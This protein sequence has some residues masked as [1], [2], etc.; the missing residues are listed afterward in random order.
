MHPV[1]HGLQIPNAAAAIRG[2]QEL[3]DRINTSVQELNHQFVRNP[4]SINTEI[5]KGLINQ[6]VETNRYLEE[7][8][9]GIYPNWWRDHGD[10]A[11]FAFLI[12]LGFGSLA[13]ITTN[14]FQFT[15]S[16]FNTDNITETNC[17]SRSISLLRRIGP[18]VARQALRTAAPDILASK[19]FQAVLALFI[20]GVAC[21]IIGGI[22]SFYADRKNKKENEIN[23]NLANLMQ[24]RQVGEENLAN[25]LKI[26][27]K[28][29]TLPQEERD[30]GM[31]TA[32]VKQIKKMP[33]DG[34]VKIKK[35]NL[36]PHMIEDLPH[37]NPLFIDYALLKRSLPSAHDRVRNTD[38]ADETPPTDS[39][40]SSIDGE[41][42]SAIKSMPILQKTKFIDPLKRYKQLWTTV[43]GHLGFHIKRLRV[44]ENL[45][46]KNGTA[47]AAEAELVV[48]EMQERS[49]IRI[50]FED[51]TYP[52][53][54]KVTESFVE[55]E[56]LN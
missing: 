8:K 14:I 44:G 36:V 23:Q 47:T 5:L 1:S 10:K 18:N 4:D 54:T 7:H 3:L 49:D 34:L 19:T 22:G 16:L 30:T 15:P 35:E 11:S 20:L 26:L 53:P 55:M 24:L 25:I 50:Q 28:F 29:K 32:C 45:L 38:S 27:E 13:L 46:H 40:E 41:Q 33:K 31:I 42:I 6:L 21:Q 51:N 52:V 12:V 39:T 9:Q 48:E 17:S 56:E 43:E 2:R 37:E